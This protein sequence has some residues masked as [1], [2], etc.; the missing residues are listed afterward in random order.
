MEKQGSIGK[1]RKCISSKK[2]DGRGASGLEGTVHEK[3]D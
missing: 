1:V 3:E 2:A